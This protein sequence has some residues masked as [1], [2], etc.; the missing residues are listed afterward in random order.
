MKSEER[1]KKLRLFKYVRRNHSIEKIIGDKDA[2]PKTRRRSE[3][4][5]CL[6]S[7]LEPKIVKED[8]DNENWIQAMNE[9]RKN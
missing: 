6:V 3:S 4:G 7:L 9:E 8:L 2:R 1:R 5:T